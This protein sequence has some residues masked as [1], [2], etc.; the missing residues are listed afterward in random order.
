[1][2]TFSVLLEHAKSIF[3]SGPL[4]CSLILECSAPTCSH[5]NPLHIVQISIQIQVGR[6]AFL[7]MLGT[8]AIFI[9]FIAVI[10]TQY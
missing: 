7:T 6:L 10:D 1:M 4:T 9:F 2:L 8:F 3:I 5:G